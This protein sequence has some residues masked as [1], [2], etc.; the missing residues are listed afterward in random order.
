MRVLAVT[1]MYPTSDDP[2][3]GAFVADQMDW[4]ARGGVDVA[5]EFID[6]RDSRGAYFRGLAHVRRRAA[7]SGFD[8]VHAHYGL[9]GFLASF[10][11]LPLVVS[12]CGDDLL[13]TPD[14]ARGITPMSRLQR[15]LSRYAARHA[16]EIVCKSDQL[17][18]SLPRQRDR[19]RTHVLPNGVDTTRFRPG[20]RSAARQRL[21]LH[22]SELLVLF[23]HT[24][25]VAR[26]RLDRAQAAVAALARRGTV[27]RLWVVQG[28]PHARMPDYYQAADCL[29]LTSEQEGSPNVVKEALCCDLPVVSVDVGDV[30]RWIEASSGSVLVAPEPEAIAD[31]LARVLTRRAP[32]NGDRVREQLSASRITQQLISVY[33][34]AIERARD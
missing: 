20:E 24:P 2:G 12:F 34:S 5:I 1:N 15:A 14:G 29:M 23:P 10:Q 33:Q 7:G 3:F 4:V 31:G 17:R 32:P 16:Q 11:P 28:V 18:D 27:A 13:G 6:G 26:K 21:G 22:P 8:L 9:V 30:R 19:A 25:G